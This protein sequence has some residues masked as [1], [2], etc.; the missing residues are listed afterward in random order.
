M[1]LKDILKQLSKIK[2]LAQHYGIKSIRIHGIHLDDLLIGKS[3]PTPLLVY[4][5]EPNIDD[6]FGPAAFHKDVVIYH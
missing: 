3:S 2:E 6:D 4:V 5:N 1:K